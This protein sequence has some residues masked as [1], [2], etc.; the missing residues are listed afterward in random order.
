MFIVYVVYHFGVSLAHQ[1]TASTNVHDANAHNAQELK[2]GSIMGRRI[3]VHDWPA[4]A[5]SAQDTIHDPGK[6][7]L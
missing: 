4:E 5:E 1:C 6:S 3:F 7:R 2:A